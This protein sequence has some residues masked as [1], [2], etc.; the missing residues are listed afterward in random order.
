MHLRALFGTH[1]YESRLRGGSVV[2][3]A[4]LGEQQAALH[5]AYAPDCYAACASVLSEL[6]HV[7]DTKERHEIEEA[8]V[9]VMPTLVL[10]AHLR[11][12]VRQTGA[13]ERQ[14]RESRKRHSL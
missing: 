9:E 8:L 14:P 13:T 11:P 5:L 1:E 10:L 3:L 12:G 6:L 2:D 4:G 7:A